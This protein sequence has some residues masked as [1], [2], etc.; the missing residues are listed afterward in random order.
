MASAFNNF[1]ITITDTLNIQQI[2]QGDAISTLK[3]SFPTNIPSI[4]IIPTTE[5]EIKSI[6][7]SLKPKRKKSSGYNEITRKI[8]HVCA[9]LI[10]YPLCYIYNHSL[11]TGIF[12]DHL[13]IAVVKSLYKKG[14]KTNMTN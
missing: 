6:I 1:F 5:T 9:S 3:Y 10:S 4:K 12:P 8:L 2:Q 13:K 7:H 14:D 11:H